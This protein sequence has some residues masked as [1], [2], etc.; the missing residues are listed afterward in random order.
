MGGKTMSTSFEVY[1]TTDWLPSFSLILDKAETL[2][3]TKFKDMGIICPI[4]LDLSLQNKR[5]LTLLELTQPFDIPEDDPFCVTTS[6]IE[7]G[8]YIYQCKNEKIYTDFWWD[9]LEREQIKKYEQKIRI[10]LKK[11]YHWSVV[12]Y[13][14]TDPFY[15]LAYGLFASALAELTDGLLFSDDNAW[16]YSRFPC[17]SEEFNDFFSIPS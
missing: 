4:N 7:S 6:G 9:E 15:N 1:P 12:R 16:E 13:A 10:S 2:I 3:K 8:F 17:I 11:S 14:G 5:G